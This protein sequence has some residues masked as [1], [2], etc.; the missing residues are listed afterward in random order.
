VPLGQAGETGRQ[1]SATWPVVQQREVDARQA[2][3]RRRQA[4]SVASDAAPPLR[5]RRYV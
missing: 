3:E 5:R 1:V 2:G 4:L